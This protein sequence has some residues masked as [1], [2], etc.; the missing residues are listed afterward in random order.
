MCFQTHQEKMPG[1]DSLFILIPVYND[2]T[3][4]NSVIT[5]LFS[6][7]YKNVVVIDDG[8]TQDVRGSITGTCVHYLKHHINLGQGAALQTGIDY[9]LN[10]G[11][12]IIVT[13]DADGQHDASDIKALSFCITNDLADVALGSRFL[14]R[15]RSGVRFRRLIILELARLVNFIFSGLYLSDAHNGLRAFN[16]K[17][18]TSL[19]I[20]ENRMA[21][22]SEILFQIK[23]H[24]LRHREIPVNVRYSA[25]SM[26]KGQSG[27]NSIR[28]LLDIIIYKISN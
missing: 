24:R 20:T 17:A 9:A 6:A 21:H 22:A 13:F 10:Q 3:T 16:H 23:Q 7:G 14:E 26:G 28:I 18:A 8:S 4:I 25:Y 5:E 1:T 27:W 2:A 11:A 12:K 15:S 19:T